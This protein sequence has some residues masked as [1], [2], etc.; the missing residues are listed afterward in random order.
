MERGEE[1]MTVNSAEEANQDVA[2]SKA[3]KEL[4]YQLADDDFLISFRGSEWLGLAPHIEED[5]AFS[6]IT[7]N[8]MGHAFMFY[9]LLEDL[10]EGEIDLLAHERHPDVRRNGIYLEKRNGE[11]NYLEEPYYDW[12]LTVVRHFLYETF[13]KVKLEAI[14]KSSYKPL[15]NIAGKVLMEQPYHLAHWRI[16][17]NQLLNSTEEARDRIE[18]RLNEA[19]EEFGDVLEFGFQATEMEHFDLI[20]GEEELKER[21]M[22][23]VAKTIPNLPSEPLGKKFGSG[24]EGQ[25]TEDLDQALATL[26]EVYLSDK[27]AIW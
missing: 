25:H 15:A 27:E 12:A 14:T 5:V 11:G 24:R 9:Q 18:A 4:I 21:W 1:V 6:S 23:E 22:D 3:L 13:K 7:Q 20:I 26:S 8:T 2:Y 19:W 17:M 10:G 16:W